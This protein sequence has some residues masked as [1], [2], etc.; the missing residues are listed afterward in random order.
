V[1][2]LAGTEVFNSTRTRQALIGDY[3]TEFAVFK[4]PRMSTGVAD[5]PSFSGLPD[6]VQVGPYTS[7]AVTSR[8]ARVPRAGRMKGLDS[9]HA[10]HIGSCPRSCASLSRVCRAEWPDLVPCQTTFALS[11]GRGRERPGAGDR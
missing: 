5:Q 6:P 1:R 3:G 11:I 4:P 10:P 2:R 7:G 9:H 8:T